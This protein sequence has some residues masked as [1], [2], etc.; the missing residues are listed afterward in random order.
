VSQAG[1]RGRG[2]RQGWRVVV[3]VFL[4]AFDTTLLRVV[5]QIGFRVEPPGVYALSAALLLLSLL[6]FYLLWRSPPEDDSS[7][8]WML[9]GPYA[10]VLPLVGIALAL[11]HF[12]GGDTSAPGLPQVLGSLALIVVGFV[13]WAGLLA[14]EAW[15][16]S[17]RR[18]RLQRERRQFLTKI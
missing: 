3:Y 7:L 12:I 8:R 18:K 2:R 10:F 11:Y 17:A 6:P 13:L 4:L 9:W 15:A 16:I 5:L 1:K 14:V